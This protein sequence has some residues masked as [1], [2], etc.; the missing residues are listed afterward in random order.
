MEIKYNLDNGVSR[1]GP[2]INKDYEVNATKLQYKKHRED[3]LD[4]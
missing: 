3:V 1:V 2:V 4:A